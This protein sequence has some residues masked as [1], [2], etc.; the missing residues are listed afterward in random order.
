MLES[1]S[2]DIAIDTTSSISRPLLTLLSI[3]SIHFACSSQI[4]HLVGTSCL[5]LIRLPSILKNLGKNMEK[6]SFRHVGLKFCPNPS[7]GFECYCNA[8][9][10]ENWNR[11]R[12]HIDSSTAKSQSGWIIFYAK[13]PI[14]WTSKSQSQ[15]ALS[16]TEAEY[17]TMSMDLRDVIPVVEL[18]DEMKSRNFQVLCTKPIV[19][20]KGF[21]DNSGALEL[22]CLPK[23][24]QQM[25]HIYVC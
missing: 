21:E 8:D 11:D 9:F 18:Q 23:L 19:Y 20:C 16:T 4:I 5:Q 10:S 2:Q 14:I 13:F 1:P 6:Q 3:M 15:V 24:H 12:A 17:I 25:K 22:A 7:K